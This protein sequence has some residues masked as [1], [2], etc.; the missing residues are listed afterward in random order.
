M[1]GTLM[2]S[3]QRPAR[4]WLAASTLCG[5]AASCGGPSQPPLPPRASLLDQGSAAIGF[6][7]PA[8]W[9]YHPKKESALLARVE[10]GPGRE[11]FAGERGER[12]LVDKK[13]KK[14]EAAARLA[15]E[16]LIAVLKTEDGGWLFVGASGTG[17]E[18]RQP[19]GPFVRS[20]APLD[21]LARVTAAGST[22]VGVTQH[23]VLTRSVDAGASWQAV[24]AK[25]ARFVDVALDEKGRGLALAVP[26]RL[27]WTENEGA[28]W[29]AV[30]GDSVGA[31][32][33]SQDGTSTIVVKTAL[34][35]RVWRPGK[36]PALEPIARAPRKSRYRLALPPSRGPDAGALAAG[37]ALVLGGRYLEAAES[38][39]GA[40]RW[41]LWSGRIDGALTSRPL[42]VARGCRTLR[43][44]GFHRWLY[45]ACAK[46]SATSST[47]SLELSR[48]DDGGKT[49]KSEP[50]ELEGKLADLDL[51]VGEGGR[52]LVTGVCTSSTRSRGCSPYGV[53]YRRLAK[54][55]DD[56]PK[57]SERKKAEEKKK[58]KEEKKKKKPEWELALAAAPSL[59]GS[60]DEIAFAPDGK[61]AFAVGRRTKNNA[62]AVFVSR[63]GGE[64][65]EAREIDQIQPADDSDGEERYGYYGRRPQPTGGKVLG[66]RAA[67]DGTFGIVFQRDSQPVVVVTDDEGRIVSLSRPPSGANTVGIAGS[68]GIALS[69]GTRQAW[70]TLDGGATWDPIG[71]LPLDLCP[72]NGQCQIP[73]VCHASGCVVG[74]ELSRVGWRGQADDDQ[75]V[76]TSLDERTPDL[77]D[78]KVRTPISCALEEGA[79]RGL[80]GVQSA[81]R[82]H[83]AAIGKVAWFAAVE[84]RDRAAAAILHAYGG[85]RP[86]VDTVQLLSPAQRPSDHA[87][88]VSTQV[89]GVAA[90]RYPTPESS[91][92]G[93]LRN[94][95]LAWSNLVEGKVVRAKIPDAGAYRPGD[96]GGASGRAQM[97][98]P[99]LLSI[100]EGGLYLR[101]HY[102]ARDDQTTY[103]VDG[104]SV[105]TVPA[106]DWPS[107]ESKQ[108]RTEM[109]RVGGTHVPLMVVDGGAA[110][111]RARRSGSSWSFDAY[112]TGLSTP[113]EFGLEQSWDI[114][115][116]K[117]RAGLHVLLFDAQGSRR[118]GMLFPF[119]ATGAAVDAPIAVP[120]QLDAGD[121]PKRCGSGHKADTP[122]IVAPYQGG[123]RHAI[124]VTDA[125][126]P[127]RVLLTGSAVMHGTPDDPCV[128]A[129]DATLV[130]I[131]TAGLGGGGIVGGIGSYGAAPGNEREEA[132]VLLDDLDHA[133]LFRHV[134]APSGSTRVEY[135]SMSCRFD[136]GVE[137][138]L[139]V[140][141]APGTLVRRSR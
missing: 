120:S 136:S 59:K 40:R 126:E 24:G 23:G 33:L 81:P 131:D 103:F 113:K 102:S 18:A 62:F 36:T 46:S 106:V 56:E 86:R 134:S 122:R 98:R 97:A 8:R 85:A 37:R 6:A 140:Y 65:F 32:A 78:R 43:L 119:R 30:P 89:E 118:S 66:A 60:A 112:A 123:T 107:V 128:A 76:L 79:W 139:E 64:S 69:P 73:V 100:G 20:S 44:A 26:E 91:G 130:P 55:D 96:Y 94:L 2:T 38:A 27:F 58:K 52:L 80:D 77:F 84:D 101:P 45:L 51:A 39:E 72:G 133:W 17:Y 50:Y 129:F 141:D 47:Q 57:K 61:T 70:E 68:H 110:I 138:P 21:R 11:L 35:T 1:P 25:D 13:A 125:A 71:R 124:V 83:H 4:S 67:E 12:W 28:T 3:S 87:L 15:P 54:D 49:W 132:I 111:V 9:R 31:Y 114:S 34:G 116:A 22:I 109:A 121:K 90:L 19:L 88:D 29:K 115:Y 117:D 63:D 99:A 74:H 93:R 135:R 48:S 5:L 95:E 7:S 82:A 14:V 104:R 92:A 75:G 127:M 16:S 10:L 41:D 108:R 42:E 137:I 105:A 53:H